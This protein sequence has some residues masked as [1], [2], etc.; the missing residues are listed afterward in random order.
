MKSHKYSGWKNKPIKKQ[1]LKEVGKIKEIH[2]PLNIETGKVIID[3]GGYWIYFSSK[4][5]NRET[6]NREITGK[7]LFFSN[8]REK[9]ILIAIDEIENNNFNR[10]KVSSKPNEK[11]THVLC[12]YYKDDSRK[13][14]LA[15]KYKQKK[16]I[17]YRYWKSDYETDQHI[18]SVDF[19]KDFTH[20]YYI[21]TCRLCG[22]KFTCDAIYFDEVNLYGT[23]ADLCPK[24]DDWDVDL[25]L[26]NAKKE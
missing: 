22:H 14:E 24:C 6:Y 7:Y 19:A 17:Q 10:A 9:L 12:L 2:K 26:I 25:E 3:D 11:G 16:D 15:N 21:V 5:Y 23:S 20:P 8:I 4:G 1:E 13:N 18:Y